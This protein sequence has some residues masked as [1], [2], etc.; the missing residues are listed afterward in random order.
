MS[1]KPYFVNASKLGYNIQS[2]KHLL[3]M[4]PASSYPSNKGN[5]P[6]VSCPNLRVSLHRPNL[7]TL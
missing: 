3:R 5:P 2:F 4:H 1:G 7:I 6:P